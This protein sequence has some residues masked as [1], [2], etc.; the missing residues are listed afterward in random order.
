[1]ADYTGTYTSA[2]LKATYKITVANG[3]L[4]LLGYGDSAVTLRSSI[5]DEFVSGQLPVIGYIA[6][7][8]QR[9]GRD[10]VSGLKLFSAGVRDLQFEKGN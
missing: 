9:S 4:E 1:M 8:F 7:L 3:N 2:E 10:H 6:V 5:K